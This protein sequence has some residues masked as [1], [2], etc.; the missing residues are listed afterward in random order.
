MKKEGRCKP[1]AGRILLTDLTAMIAGWPSIA[2]L[3]IEVLIISGGAWD[4]GLVQSV[5]ERELGSPEVILALSFLA[6][7]AAR[8]VFIRSIFTRGVVVSGRL[9]DDVREHDVEITYSYEWEGQ[10]YVNM[11]LLVF[12]FLWQGEA[13]FD[14]VMDPRRPS[15][16]FIQGILCPE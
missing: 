5:R 2:L 6:I 10:E 8:V 11:T 1:R 7:A 12:R 14:V 9:K 13:T 16:S 4:K 15:R 3:S